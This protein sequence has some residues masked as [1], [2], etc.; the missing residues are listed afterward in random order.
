MSSSSPFAE[1]IEQRLDCLHLRARSSLLLGY[2]ATFNRILLAISLIPTGRVKVR[3]E[4]FTNIGI[5]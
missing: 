5:A 3:G 1:R 2:F 4:R